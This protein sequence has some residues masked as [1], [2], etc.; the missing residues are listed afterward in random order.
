MVVD[1]RVRLA[2]FAALSRVPKRAGQLVAARGRRPILLVTA[3]P[4]AG[5]APAATL[6]SD[7]YEAITTDLAGALATVAATPLDCIVVAGSR[8]PDIA[9][10]VAALR[11]VALEHH[12]PILVRGA[13]DHAAAASEILACGADDYVSSEAGPAL[14]L[15][16]L[17]TLIR[18]NE[19]AA[20]DRRVRDELLTRETEASA[21]RLRAQLAESESAFKSRFL[22]IMSHELRTPLN[23]ILGFTQL[24]DR[25]VGGGLSSSQQ[26]HVDGVR[27]SAQHLL[28][29]VNDVLDLSKV[30]AG[31]LSLRRVPLALEEVARAVVVT[32]STMAEQRGV[33]L[34]VDVPSD[35]PVIYGDHVRMQQ[36]LCNLM[37]NGIKFTGRGGTVTLTGRAADAGVKLS[38]RDTGIGIRHEDFDRLFRDF[39]RLETGQAEQADGTGLGL[40][41]TK[42]LVELHG[43]RIEVESEFGSGSEFSIWLPIGAGADA[44]A[45]DGG[46]GPGG[47]RAQTS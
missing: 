15:A 43:G 10:A 29:L 17:R 42:Y 21:A 37:S 16:R 31:K 36:M 24:L 20:E 12:V 32:V 45:D 8:L 46:D 11:N 28:E 5:T 47:D 4:L 7:E 26:K 34:Q 9:D 33:V 14:Y 25:G 1:I 27:R 35:L 44:D 40:S 18:R 2:R 30:R 39:E 22:A 19:V 41:L 13:S 6:P 38:V 23:A 3:A